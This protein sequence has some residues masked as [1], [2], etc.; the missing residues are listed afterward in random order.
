MS[1]SP[2]Q[3]PTLWEV[4]KSVLAAMFGVQSNKTRE[5]DFQH[6]N[7]IAFIVVGIVI[8]I[9]F[10]LALVAVVQMVLHAQ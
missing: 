10:V 1:S 3:K 8:G 6:G 2:V 7:P 9:L 5:R 4:I